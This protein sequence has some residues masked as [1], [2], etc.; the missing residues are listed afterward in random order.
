MDLAFGGLRECYYREKWPCSAR[1]W[2]NVSFYPDI[3]RRQLGFLLTSKG[4]R[5]AFTLPTKA[6]VV[7]LF[8]IILLVDIHSGA[9]DVIALSH[10]S[11]LGAILSNT[12]H[13][14][15]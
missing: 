12:N 6:L 10:F 13:G 9:M 14:P 5:R 11:P 15:E 1:G 7:G 8:N 3:S 4:Q 2:G